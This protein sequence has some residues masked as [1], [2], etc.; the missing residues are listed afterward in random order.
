MATN[1]GWES[2]GVAD[3]GEWES[4]KP[5]R[6]KVSKL[7]SGIRGAV[8]GFGMDFGDEITGALE[9]TAGSLGLVPDKTYE[10]ARDESRAAYAQAREDNPGTYLSGQVGG[11]LASM[12]IPGLN[13]AKGAK[14]A[15]VFGKS[16]LQGGLMGL[17]ASESDDIAGMAKDT[18]TGAGIGGAFGAAGGLIGNA[19]SGAVPKTKKAIDEIAEWLAARSLGAERGT[20]KKIGADKVRKAGRYALDKGIISPLASAD[21]LIARN[22]ASLAASGSGGRAVRDAIDEAGLSTFNPLNTASK[23]DDEVGGFWRSPINRGE[24]KQHE[25][26]LEAILMR[27]S[28]GI[29]KDIPLSEAQTLKEEL[30]KVANWKNN[31]NVTDKERMARDAYRI[32][33]SGIDDAVESGAAKLNNPEMLKALKEANKTYSTGKTAEQLL[34]NKFAREQGNK[35][36]G[37]TDSIVGVG[38]LGYG[39]ATDDWGTAGAIFGAKKFA[40]KYGTQIGAVG[41]NNLAKIIAKSPQSLG[42][43]GDI[44][45]KA[46]ARGGSSLAITH[47]MLMERDPEY[48]QTIEKNDQ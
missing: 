33:A 30:G 9:S 40:G 36:F 2:I 42:K 4:I 44:L 46:M 19:A 11:G 28:K 7:E 16:A 29:D 38:S 13:A 35:L 39:G 43:Y 27:N 22:D 26:T 6:E 15:T 3:E 47:H 25:N 37:L 48:R 8:Q 24:T 14:L 31:L 20:I 17:G 41:L 23:I 21:D 34:E 32:V 18:A 10:Q 45:Q 1:D 5:E 12:A